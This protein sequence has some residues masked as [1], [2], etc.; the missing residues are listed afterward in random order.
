MTKQEL[1][2]TLKRRRAEIPAEA[3]RE[4]DSVIAAGIAATREFKNA[5]ALLIYAPIGTEI[6]L[7]PLVRIA[8][9]RGIP[10]AFPRCDTETNTLQFYTLLPASRLTE[11]A[12]G[13]PEPPADAPLCTP[14]ER[15]LCILP[16][17]SFDPTGSRIGYGKG[18][19]D[20][21][22]ATFPGIR[23]GACYSSMILKRVPTEPHDLP[24][25]LLVTERGILR[26]R[27]DESARNAPV[28]PS[29]RTDT[30]PDARAPREETCADQG[31]YR[32]AL[33]RLGEGCRAL[34]GRAWAWITRVTEPRG[35]GI[36]P[37]HEPPI[38]V[39]AIFLLLLLSRPL[40]TLLA[41]RDNELAVAV[42][43]QV[44]IFALPTVLYGILRG[45]KRP[46]SRIRIA[47]PRLSHLWFC[48]WMLVVMISGGMLF[49]I[50][51]GGIASLE[52][53]FTLYNTF[54][55]HTG[56][57]WLDTL[58]LLCT[59]ALLPALGEELV[60]R[61]ILCAEYEKCGAWVAILASGC[62]FA[63][64]HFSLPLFPAYLLLG[65]LLAAATYT[66]R[67]L[68]VPIVLHFCYNVFCLFGQPYLSA[69]YN[70]AASDEIFVFCLVVIFLLFSAFAVGEARKIY[71]RYA[72]QSL[73]SSY[74]VPLDW[75]RL[76]RTLLRAAL[77]P[78][79]LVCVAIF[80][81]TSIVSLVTA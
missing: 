80:L 68:I 38:L 48:L 15:A 59:Y 12:Y 17:L 53:N 36:R 41:T 51:T 5:S 11:G 28:S 81:V 65:I 45:G 40:D 24:V 76:P 2:A 1:R 4:M 42:L 30:A 75:R 32:E 71:H 55:A 54:V 47:L 8:R 27:P 25:S 77:S 66:T 49:G 3:R 63:M 78:V 18:Y 69:F 13:I 61:G 20:R 26:C 6:N 9:E 57:S 50:L 33:H 52:G 39:L 23:M 14:D 29:D 34:F 58:A 35:E 7:L 37:Q 62:F 73:D 56:G 72:K 70:H 60:F 22:L 10:V 79:T 31:G 74:T 43:L 44:M 21:Y 19:Y 46:L 67:S 16:A 64:L